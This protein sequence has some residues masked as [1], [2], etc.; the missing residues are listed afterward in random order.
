MRW[1]DLKNSLKVS[2]PVLAKHIKRLIS[3]GLIKEQVDPTDRRR[4]IYFLTDAGKK[5]IAL[6][7]EIYSKICKK[8]S[9]LEKRCKNKLKDKTI[10]DNYNDGKILILWEDAE[11]LIQ[12]LSECLGSLCLNTLLQSNNTSLKEL[13]YLLAYLTESL[14]DKIHLIKDT[15][16]VKFSDFYLS[17]QHKEK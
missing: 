2:D 5:A 15:T 6:E 4:K 16:I 8:L 3:K 1:L 10:Y 7:K 17:F 14:I 13:N 11:K 12:I 9:E